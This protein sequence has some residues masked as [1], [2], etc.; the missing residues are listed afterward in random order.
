VNELPRPKAR[1][2]PVDVD[3]R[4]LV[5]VERGRILLELRPESGRMA[6]LWQLPTIETSGAELIAPSRWPGDANG[7]PLLLELE[8]LGAVR[9]AITH[10]RIRADVVL[11]S[12]TGRRLP[13]HCAWHAL[14]ELDDLARTGMTKKIL[15]ARFLGELPA[16]RGNART[17]GLNSRAALDS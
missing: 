16:F 14:T 13:P 17:S 9:H 10:H 15:G 6:G 3:L 11:G 7:S 12:T 5:V 1:K 4:V 2:E 8:R